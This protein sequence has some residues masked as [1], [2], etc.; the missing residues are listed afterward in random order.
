MDADNPGLQFGVLGLV[1]GVGGLAF[2]FMVRQL[3]A[4][5]SA[6]ERHASAEQT[7]QALLKQM[8][9]ILTTAPVGIAFTRFRRFEIISTRWAGMMGYSEAELLAMPTHQLFADVTSYET[10]GPKVAQA[11]AD[12]RVFSEEFEFRRKD[13]SSFWG[14]LQGSPVDEDDASSGT[15]WIL[16]D[17]THERDARERLSWMAT[18]DALTGLLNRAAFET[19][20]ANRLKHRPMS[21]PA[22]LLYIDI[23]HFKSINDTHGHAAGDQVLIGVADILRAGVR[24]SD[25]VARLGGDEFAV[26]LMGCDGAAAARI[27]EQIR[28]NVESKIFTFDQDTRQAA[29]SLGV[30][31]FDE[32]TVDVPT[33]M[34]AA[35]VALY[36]AKKSGRNKVRTSGFSDLDETSSSGQGAGDGLG[37]EGLENV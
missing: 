18:H 20:V 21:L 3:H 28:Q 22:A 33:A 17:V 4:L 8:H 30:A 13:G 36:K 15:T 5:A 32:W 2:G 10:L 31:E 29:V 26:L 19:M 37:L 27:A 25:T 23:D 12:R 24:S 6:L 11:F 16:M 35:D 1:A 9:S 14:R 7:A 34:Q